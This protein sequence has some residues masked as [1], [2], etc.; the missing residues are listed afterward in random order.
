MP[1]GWSNLSTIIHK[2]FISIRT[3]RNNMIIGKKLHETDIA[4]YYTEAG[5]IGTGVTTG[6]C[7]RR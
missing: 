1:E 2:G 4:I 5:I 6:D 3:V 7:V